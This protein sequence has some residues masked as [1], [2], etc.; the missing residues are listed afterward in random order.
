MKHL[1]SY[2][3]IH[4]KTLC[5]WPTANC[6]QSN[7]T[8]A[9]NPPSPIRNQHTSNTNLIRN[10]KSRIHNNPINKSANHETMI[11]ITL[12]YWLSTLVA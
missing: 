8:S 11:I 12:A 5:I 2:E 10:P 9:S 3:T 4:M 7:Q 6:A 1:H